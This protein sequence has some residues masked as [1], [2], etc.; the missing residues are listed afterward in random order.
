[1]NIKPI[2]KYQPPKNYNFTLT[3]SFQNIT[4]NY[5]EN[6]DITNDL[7]INKKYVESKYNIK[8]NSDIILREFSLT[9]KNIKFQ[10]FLLYIDGMVDSDLINKFVLNPLMI[11]NKSNTFDGGLKQEIPSSNSKNTISVKKVK[12]L[13]LENYIYSNLIPQNNLEK[14]QQETEL[15]NEQLRE[16]DNYLNTESYE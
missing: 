16:F 15:M 5:E 2:F 1:M 11:R 4:N 3:P 7:S 10:S 13:N 14:I 6:K 12:Q 9:A 8:I